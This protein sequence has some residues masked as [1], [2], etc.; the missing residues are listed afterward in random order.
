MASVVQLIHP[1]HNRQ[2]TIREY[3]R[4]M[5]YPDTFEFFP[6]ECKTETVQCIAQGVPVNFIKYVH[7]EIHEA[8]DGNRKLLKEESKLLNF[9]HHIKKQHQLFSL[10]ELEQLDKLDVI[11]KA[12]KLEK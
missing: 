10:E 5:G 1:I 12:P 3:A 7:S 6:N 8:L 11:K 9:Q 4:L 2:F